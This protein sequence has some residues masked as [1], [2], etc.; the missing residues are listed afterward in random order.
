M[1]NIRL[2]RDEINYICLAWNI[3]Q[4]SIYCSRIQLSRLTL[5]YIIYLYRTNGVSYFEDKNGTT[6]LLTMYA[7]FLW[8][9][10][11]FYIR[12]SSLITRHK[13]NCDSLKVACF[14]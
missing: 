11:I 9:S 6:S 5:P 4:C 13:W 8:N 10:T 12:N 2:S 3:G 7:V 1:G 14:C